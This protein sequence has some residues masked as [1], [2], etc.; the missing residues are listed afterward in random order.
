MN[1]DFDEWFSSLP[2]IVKSADI[3]CADAMSSEAFAVGG[4]GVGRKSPPPQNSPI[5]SVTQPGCCGQSS[6]GIITVMAGCGSSRSSHRASNGPHTTSGLIVIA[7][8]QP[9]LP[10]QLAIILCRLDQLVCRTKRK[11]KPAGNGANAQ[12]AGKQVTDL[13]LMPLER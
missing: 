9:E 6:F 4:W 1:G 5:A 10:H 7:Q 13:L 2:P 8:T 12:A 11:I 3:N